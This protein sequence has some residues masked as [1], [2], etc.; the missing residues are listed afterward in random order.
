MVIYDLDE[1]VH[2]QKMT[3]NVESIFG[4]AGYQLNP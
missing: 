2:S 1:K 4:A 3:K